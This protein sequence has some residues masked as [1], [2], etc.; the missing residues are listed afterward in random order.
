MRWRQIF[1]P[2]FWQRME[3][4]LLGMELYIFIQV[5]WQRLGVSLLVQNIR[6]R[7]IGKRIVLFTLREAENIGVKEDVLVLT[8]LPNFFLKLGF[9]EIP[10]DTVPEH[11]IWADCIKCIHFPICNEVSLVYKLG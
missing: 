1:V 4:S 7:N 3:K 2:M 8:Y 5:V 9:I 11:K 6:G 10:K